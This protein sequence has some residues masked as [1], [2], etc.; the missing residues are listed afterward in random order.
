MYFDVSLYNMF[1][2]SSYPDYSQ[3]IIVS[4]TEKDITVAVNIPD[5]VTIEDKE[6]SLIR[7]HNGKLEIIP[8]K[9]EVIDGKKKLVFTTNKFSTY[10]LAYTD[11]LKTGEEETAPNPK[12]S[13]SILGYL[14]LFVSSISVI[15]YMNNKRKINN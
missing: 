10:A 11:T 6:L 7:L 4:E 14:V 8:V 12:T 1:I 3:F 15:L 5:N 13:D 2:S 9:V